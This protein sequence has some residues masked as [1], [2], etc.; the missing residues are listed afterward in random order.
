MGFFKRAGRVMRTGKQMADLK[1]D[2]PEAWAEG[3]AAAI[4]ALETRSDDLVRMLING[5]ED[6]VEDYRA[7]MTEHLVTEIGSGEVEVPFPTTQEDLTA[8]AISAGL[9]ITDVLQAERKEGRRKVPESGTDIG[10]GDPVDA[11]EKFAQIAF[12]W[13]LQ[14]PNVP[15]T[16]EEIDAYVHKTVPARLEGVAS[17]LG[18]R[19]GD[20]PGDF[21]APFESAFK[22]RLASLFAERRH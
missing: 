2:H 18:K 1:F 17:T 7:Q 16:T 19:P 11:G 14:Q 5:P 8:F 12:D 9:T 4:E 10:L 21:V 13:S 15:R 3:E 20:L 6:R 22:S